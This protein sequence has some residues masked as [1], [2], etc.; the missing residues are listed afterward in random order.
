VIVGYSNYSGFFINI[1]W[2]LVNSI[3]WKIL[4]YFL[5]YNNN[6]LETKIPKLKIILDSVIFLIFHFTFS[7][8]ILKNLHI[9]RPTTIVSWTFGL[10][11]NFQTILPCQLKAIEMASPFFKKHEEKREFWQSRRYRK[12]WLEIDCQQRSLSNINCSPPMKVMQ[13][14]LLPGVKRLSTQWINGLKAEE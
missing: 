13:I 5:V 11:E 8:D 6:N 10:K 14:Y 4:I 12:F 1:Y 7:I 9:W 3:E 2:V